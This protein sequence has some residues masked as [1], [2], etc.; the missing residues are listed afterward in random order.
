METQGRDLSI[1][2]IFVLMS[3]QVVVQRSLYSMVQ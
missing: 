2:A 1:D 3:S